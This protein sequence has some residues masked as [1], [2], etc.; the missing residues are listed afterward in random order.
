MAAASRGG[1]LFG[2]LRRRATYHART[3]RLRRFRQRRDAPL[4]WFVDGDAVE[5]L[6]I[7]EER[8]QPQRAHGVI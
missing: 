1:E 8:R 5:V 6:V 7:E 3:L 4:E 2:G